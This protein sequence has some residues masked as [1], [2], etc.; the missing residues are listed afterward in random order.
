MSETELLENNCRNVPFDS[1]HPRTECNHYHIT[2]H[3]KRVCYRAEPAQPCQNLYSLWSKSSLSLTRFLNLALCYFSFQLR[4]WGSPVDHLVVQTQA[5]Y[6]GQQSTLS[7]FPASLEPSLI[8]GKSPKL[9]GFLFVAEMCAQE[10]KIDLSEQKKNPNK[11]QNKN[12]KYLWFWKTSPAG[13]KSLQCF[14]AHI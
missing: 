10:Y 3:Y 2:L 1:T 9:W 4:C 8:K 11:Q 12:K 14:W 5:W 13:Q 7:L 6:M